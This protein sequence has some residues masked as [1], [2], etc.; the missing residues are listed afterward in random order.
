M[1]QENVKN[2]PVNPTHKQTSTWIYN[3]YRGTGGDIYMNTLSSCDLHVCQLCHCH[4]YWQYLIVTT[5]IKYC[6]TDTVVY[7][8][9][10]THSS[11]EV[12][13]SVTG[14]TSV[15]SHVIWLSFTSSWL[16]MTWIIFC[17]TKINKILSRPRPTW[18][19][20]TKVQVTRWTPRLTTQL[21]HHCILGNPVIQ[22][23]MSIGR[24]PDINCNNTNTLNSK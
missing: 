20:L 11:V 13:F 16:V 10:V 6:Y 1:K 14:M 23:N 24:N 4:K 21:I 8:V 19:L 5:I 7:V 22:R 18:G 3:K 12:T 17:D 9:T 2:K 15:Q